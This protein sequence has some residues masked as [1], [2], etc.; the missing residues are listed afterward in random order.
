MIAADMKV[1]NRSETGRRVREQLHAFLDGRI[2]N[3]DTELFDAVWRLQAVYRFGYAG[4]VLAALESGA[5]AGAAGPELFP[6]P[7]E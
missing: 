2:S 4:S 7:E 1:L 3:A 6:N 5:Q